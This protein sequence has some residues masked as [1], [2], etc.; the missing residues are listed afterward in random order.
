[1]IWSNKNLLEQ[2]DDSKVPILKNILASTLFVDFE[3]KF[4]SEFWNYPKLVWRNWYYIWATSYTYDII[5]T[6][7]YCACALGHAA[8]LMPRL[9]TN[10]KP[11]NY[12]IFSEAKFF[13]QFDSS[14]N[15]EIFVSCKLIFQT[16]DLVL[17]KCCTRSLS[18]DIYKFFFA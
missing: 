11:S 6:I 8:W 18:L 1:M 9:K 7:S 17:R 5:W 12:L 15:C 2:L 10:C 16:S 14:S 13:A 3:T 4:L